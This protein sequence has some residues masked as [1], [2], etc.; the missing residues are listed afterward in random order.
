MLT[1]NL[2]RLLG[3]PTEVLPVP[4]Q[5]AYPRAVVIKEGI[6]AFLGTVA[7]FAIVIF[8]KPTPYIGWPLTA[9]GLL[10]FSYLYQ[11]LSRYFLRLHVDDTGLIQELAGMRKA[12]RWTGL[13]DLRLNFYPQTKGANQGT[14]VLILKEGKRRIKVDSTLDHF[15][16][17]LSKASAAAR[18]RE[19]FLHPTTAE[20]LG[21]LGL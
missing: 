19:I 10:F 21:H 4:L 8:L 2:T 15:P 9:V 13:T 3:R 1:E 17:V 5:P 11:Q 20:N 6:K 12:I 18:E 16:T 14:L 7:I